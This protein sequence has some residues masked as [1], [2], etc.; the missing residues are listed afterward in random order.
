[1]FQRPDVNCFEA[2]RFSSEFSFYVSANHTTLIM[3]RNVSRSRK[4]DSLWTRRRSRADEAETFVENGQR[5]QARDLYSKLRPKPD[6]VAP[7]LFWWW[8]FTRPY[9]PNSKRLPLSECLSGR[10][11]AIDILD[12][13]PDGYSSSTHKSGMAQ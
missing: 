7:V 6:I 12:H 8:R 4:K 9:K 2:H 10:K 11:T 13:L 3:L 1:M 5:E